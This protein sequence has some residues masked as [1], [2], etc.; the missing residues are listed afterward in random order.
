MSGQSARLPDRLSPADPAQERFDPA[1][2]AGPGRSAGLNGSGCRPDGTR[3]H[4]CGCGRL[5]HL[6][7]RDTVRAIWQVD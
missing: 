2:S 5:R 1:S 3:H 6:C 4:R 7:L